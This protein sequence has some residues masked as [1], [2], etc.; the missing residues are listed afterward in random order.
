MADPPF[1]LI[2]IVRIASMAAEDNY[3]RFLK[4]SLQTLRTSF[5]IINSHTFTR[6]HFVLRLESLPVQVATHYGICR[7]KTLRN[8]TRYTPKGRVNIAQILPGGNEGGFP[9]DSDEIG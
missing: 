6:R 1:M 9:R 4:S 7:F 3:V 8:H 2:T 5:L